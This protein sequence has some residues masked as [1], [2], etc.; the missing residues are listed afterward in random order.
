VNYWKIIFATVIIFG[1]GVFTGGLWFHG[2]HLHGKRL[3]PSRNQDSPA[4]STNLVMVPIRPMQ[5]LMQQLETSLQ[6]T[7]EERENI[8][9]ILD[10]GQHQIH[11]AIQDARLEVREVLP[12]EK[13]KDFDEMMKRRPRKS[14]SPTNAPGT[15]LPATV[16]NGLVK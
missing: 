6:L 14:T 4:V 16:T 2:G 15:S 9:K 10:E 5:L 1:A 7:K 8:Q 12:P 3:S 13:Q 11:K